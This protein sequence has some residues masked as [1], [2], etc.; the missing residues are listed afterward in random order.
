MKMKLVDVDAPCCPQLSTE[1]PPRETEDVTQG[2]VES[3]V[4]DRKLERLQHS[5][6]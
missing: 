2:K 4:Q 5:Q 3:L 6:N 1:I